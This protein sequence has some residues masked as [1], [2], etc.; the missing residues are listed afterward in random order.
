MLSVPHTQCIHQP[1]HPTMMIT[2]GKHPSPLSGFFHPGPP[3]YQVFYHLNCVSI[4]FLAGQI[5]VLSACP[6]HYQ[7][8]GRVNRDLPGWTAQLSGFCHGKLRPLSEFCTRRMRFLH[9]YGCKRPS[10]PG[11]MPAG[12]IQK[13]RTFDRI[14]QARL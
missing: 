7:V 6:A 2:E 5:T 12:I 8:F 4:R 14:F 11:I 9:D 1:Q 13:K 10:T 3:R